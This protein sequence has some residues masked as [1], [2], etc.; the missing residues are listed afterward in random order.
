LVINRIHIVLYR[1]K[2]YAVAIRVKYEKRITEEVMKTN[3]LITGAAGKTGAPLVE[4][5]AQLRVPVRALIHAGPE[6]QIAKERLF[7]KGAADV[8]AGDFKDAASLE[9]ALD[10]IERVYLVSPP[11]L[12]QVKVQTSFV[13]IA[14]RKGAKHIVKLSALGAASDSPVGLLRA[15]A[16]IEAHI[17][18]SGIDYTFLRPHFFM[19]NLLA[20]AATT[21]NDGAIYS[22]LSAARISPVSVQDIAAVGA[23]ILSTDGGRGKTYTLTGPESVTYADIAAALGGVINRAVRYQQVPFEAARQGMVQSGMP[24]RLVDDL[25]VMM[26]TWEEGKG[27]IVSHDIEKI[28]GRKPLSV[29]EFFEIHREAFIGAAGKAA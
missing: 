5:L 11:S 21:R 15:H 24:D 1:W 28:L 9:P 22:P 7:R 17:R 8:V 23:A 12:D 14:V 4:K 16:E 29:A 3:I 20:N 19:E 13:D 10:G 27:N 26:K 2:V 6:Q 18:K 25:I